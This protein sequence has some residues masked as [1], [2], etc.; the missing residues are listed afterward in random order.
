MEIDIV[1]RVSECLTLLAF[2]ENEEAPFS[3]FHKDLIKLMD[4]IADQH[5]ED[6]Q[7]DNE[8]ILGAFATPAE[9]IVR[10]LIAIKAKLGPDDIELEKE[11]N[12]AINN[13]TE[14]KIYNTLAS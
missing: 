4:K 3:I 12:F 5:E 13:I 9:R 11:I 1:V 14:R 10:T 6:N 7:E 2:Y 8:R